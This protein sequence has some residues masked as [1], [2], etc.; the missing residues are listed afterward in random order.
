MKSKADIFWLNYDPHGPDTRR[1]VLSP[2][3][4]RT[5]RS[6]RDE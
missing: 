6:V 1:R 2:S 5:V 4:V 3:V